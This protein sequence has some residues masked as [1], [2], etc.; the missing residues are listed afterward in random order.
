MDNYKIEVGEELIPLMLPN[1]I[2]LG[3]DILMALLSNEVFASQQ[4]KLNN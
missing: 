1:M 4:G 2:R 3:V